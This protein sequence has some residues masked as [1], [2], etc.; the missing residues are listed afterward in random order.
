[1]V[2][3][4]LFFIYFFFPIW[5]FSKLLKSMDGMLIWFLFQF[6]SRLNLLKIVEIVGWDVDLISHSIQK[7]FVFFWKLLK[8]MDRMLIWFLIKFKSYL[9]FLKIVEI[10]GCDADLTPYPIQ[11]WFEHFEYCWNKNEYDMN[12]LYTLDTLIAW[13]VDEIPH[14]W[15]LKN[16]SRN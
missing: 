16:V 14:G 11:K 1:M 4:F 8:S 7:S 6:K 10:D 15:C 3:V 2:R 5:T 12:M 13:N 9:N